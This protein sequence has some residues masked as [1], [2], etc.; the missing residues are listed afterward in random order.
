[1]VDA[2]DL[3]FGEMLADPKSNRCCCG[4]RL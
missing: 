1:V 4:K 3:R 2:V